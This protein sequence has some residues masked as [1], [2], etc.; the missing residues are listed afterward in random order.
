[1][2]N[3]T[4]ITIIGGGAAGISAAYHLVD[5][6]AK[7]T[8]APVL[9]IYVVEARRRIGPGTAYEA[10]WE[11]NLMNTRAGVLSPVEG[12]SGHFL[13]WA[14]ENSGTVQDNF[15]AWRIEPQTFVPRPLLGMYLEHL[16]TDTCRRA[17]ANGSRIIPV[18]AEATDLDIN[19]DNDILVRTDS[20]L[21]IRS[22]FVIMCQGHLPSRE[23]GLGQDEPGVFNSPYPIRRLARSIDRKSDVAL[24]GSRLSAVDAMLG[25]AAAG[26]EG[27]IHCFSRSGRLPSVR[28][29]QERYTS[30]L[31]TMDRL[32]Q[33]VATK[34]R[35]SLADVMGLVRAEIELAEGPGFDF[36]QFF[37]PPMDPVAFLD[38][39]I[40]LSQKPRMWQA[41]LYAS[42]ALFEYA[43]HH[44][45]EADKDQFLN[46]H[47]SHFISFRVS[48]PVE[49][50][51]RMRDLARA[52]RVEFH[53]GAIHVEPRGED[54]R[55]RIAAADGGAGAT[56]PVDAVISCLGT[57]RDA[58]KLN[59][60]L[61]QRM[62]AKGIMRP[63]PYGG[64]Q[65]DFDT[66]HVLGAARGS[67]PD[68][69]AIGDLTSGTHFFTSV[70]E[71]LA[72]HARMR[73][74][75]IMDQL[76]HT[77]GNQEQRPIRQA[78]VG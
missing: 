74:G 39:E 46:G 32:K 4:V 52:G 35:L 17:L 73:A 29:M 53:A 19:G 18:H 58:T 47:F 68:L 66:A 50:A 76:A 56:V 64:I 51:I 11:T 21:T 23:L 61:L 42:N 65:V 5:E 8:P 59:S 67:K 40:E 10:D 72:R 34:G 3:E 33:L 6:A 41:V 28:G 1:M 55:F 43:W 69:V 16:F 37:T 13:R 26:H 36:S 48:I 71:V 75:K 77:S 49:N 25:L 54:G 60:P 24:I 70:L 30:R 27:R 22:N 38:R 57:P 20:N 62:F 2:K 63:D 7:R 14:Q 15:P 78:A 45:A 9:T 31:L 44:M 12:D